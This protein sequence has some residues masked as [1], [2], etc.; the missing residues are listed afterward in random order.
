VPLESHGHRPRDVPC[1]QPSH[2]A[3]IKQYYQSYYRSYYRSALLI[4]STQLD[5][6][7]HSAK[8]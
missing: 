8:W 7:S 6:C 5:A 3:G 1:L 4:A 2:V